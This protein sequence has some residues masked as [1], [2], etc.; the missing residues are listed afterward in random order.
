VKS[1]PKGVGN[2]RSKRRAGSCGIGDVNIAPAF[3]TVLGVLLI[4]CLEVT[5]NRRCDSL[6]LQLIANAGGLWMGTRIRS[7]GHTIR[8]G[9]GQH[10][11]HPADAL[12]ADPFK[13]KMVAKTVRVAFS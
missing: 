6:D 9:W 3:K 11:P 10:G 8:E 12:P 7:A 1:E 2:A 4:R 13:P 5:A